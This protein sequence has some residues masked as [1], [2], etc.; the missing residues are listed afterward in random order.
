MGVHLS[1][2]PVLGRFKKR[3]VSNY[4]CHV[5]LDLVVKET[6][7]FDSLLEPHIVALDSNIQLLPDFYVVVVSGKSYLLVQQNVRYLLLLCRVL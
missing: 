2:D 5:L 6:L 3:E 1:Y 7:V 4:A